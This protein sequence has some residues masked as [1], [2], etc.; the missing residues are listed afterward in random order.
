MILETLPVG[1]L[2]CNCS[3]LGHDTS[4]EA[5]AVDPCDDTPRILAPLAKH[6][7]TVN[8]TRLTHPRTTAPPGGNPR[9]LLRSSHERLLTPPDEVTLIPGHGP[10][11][12]IGSER[13]SKP[14]LQHR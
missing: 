5:I 6:P 7:P 12:T 3:I 14:F 9:K 8:H 2:Q 4:R 1:P 11:T 13:A 10:H